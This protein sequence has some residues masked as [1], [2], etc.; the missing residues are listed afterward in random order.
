VKETPAARVRR[1][2]LARSVAVAATVALG[3]GFATTRPAHSHTRPSPSLASDVVAAQRPGPVRTIVNAV[4]GPR[5]PRRSMHHDLASYVG[6]RAGAVAVAVFDNHT[7]RLVLIHPKLRA[8]TAS[9]AKVDV[10]ETLLHRT[11]GHLS[12]RQRSLATE[13]IV[14]SDND[15]ATELWTEAG[16]DDGI[17]GYN[18]ELGLKQTKLY[19]FWSATMSTPRDQ[20]TLLRT[21][22]GPSKH[23]T[24]HS[25]LYQ[26]RLMSHVEGDQRWGI[27]DGIPKTATFGNKNGWSPI[28]VDHDRWA[29]NSIGWVRGS[30]DA[31][32]GH[33]K[34]YEIAVMT[35]H[36]ATEGYGRATIARV[37]QIVWR[38]AATSRTAPTRG[39]RAP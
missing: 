6:T 11:G 26:R 8:H 28:A 13:M 19:G 14:H 10:L 22:F 25:R 36:D 38:H 18:H 1:R 39:S 20:V 30:V 2:R 15:A 12:G 29:V 33:R 16:G 7:R 24:R 5:P 21:L 27:G 34:S 17:G 31:A 4:T 23:L 9:V 37:S 3:V 35:E 32:T